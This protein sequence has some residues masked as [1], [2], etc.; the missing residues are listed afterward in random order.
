MINNIG[1][2]IDLYRIYASCEKDEKLYDVSIKIY[3]CL[4]G[5]IINIFIN[6]DERREQKRESGN[7]KF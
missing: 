2:L 4:R 6:H 1:V 7:R 5:L 3:K